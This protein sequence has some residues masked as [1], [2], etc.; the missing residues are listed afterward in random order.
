MNCQASISDDGEDLARILGTCRAY[1][2]SK[3]LNLS[4]KLGLYTLLEQLQGKITSDHNEERR[5]SGLT[6]REIALC[7]GWR[8]H[9]GFRGAMDFLDLLVSIRMLERSGEGPEAR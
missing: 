4:C 6:W 2:T 1:K 7:M 3:A 9:E 5:G 8:T